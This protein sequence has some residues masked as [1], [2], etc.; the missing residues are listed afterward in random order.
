MIVSV[1]QNIYSSHSRIETLNWWESSNH[2]FWKSIWCFDNFESYLA[3]WHQLCARQAA[4]IIGTTL[5]E[6]EELCSM[7]TC[8]HWLY[9]FSFILSY[10][11]IFISL[12]SCFLIFHFF[13]SLSLTASLCHYSSILLIKFF[14]IMI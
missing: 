4:V 11:L 7:T 1:N 9:E 5:Q 14:L 10:S 2:W 3:R 13:Y 8:C 12:L 6:S